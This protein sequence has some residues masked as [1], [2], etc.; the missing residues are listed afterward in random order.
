MPLFIDALKE[1]NKNE[2]K[3]TVPR[4]GTKDYEQVMKIMNSLKTEPKQS[5]KEPK[6]QKE[7]KQTKKE[8]KQTKKE[9]KPVGKT[10]EKPLNVSMSSG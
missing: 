4:R 10:A 5:K 8:P 2:I 3:W 6:Q 9:P 7:P 1:Y